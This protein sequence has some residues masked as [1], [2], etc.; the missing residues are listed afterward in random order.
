MMKIDSINTAETWEDL[1]SQIEA[2]ILPEQKT[3]SIAPRSP[4]CDS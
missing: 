3:L 4:V 1:T 2:L